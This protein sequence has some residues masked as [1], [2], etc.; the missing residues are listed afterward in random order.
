M[1]Y[2]IYVPNFGAEI[3]AQALAALAHEAEQA[4]WDGFFLW[5]HILH[6][7]SQRVPLVDPW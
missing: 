6:S 3:S 5:D 2:G 7:K 1:H 4:G